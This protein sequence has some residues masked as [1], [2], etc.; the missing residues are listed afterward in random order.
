MMTT[1]DLMSGITW[2]AYLVCRRTNGR[3]SC[4]VVEQDGAEHDVAE[5]GFQQ[6][7]RVGG[8]L[9]S[10]APCETTPS[11]DEWCRI[12]YDLS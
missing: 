12:V 7:L 1:V 2:K 3:D 9:S 10:A 11:V 8:G 4:A 6:E 5:A